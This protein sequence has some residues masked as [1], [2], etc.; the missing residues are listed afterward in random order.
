[1]EEIEE[2]PGPSLT[3]DGGIP[4]F[5]MP[6]GLVKHTT[7]PQLFDTEGGLLSYASDYREQLE[8]LYAS[9]EERKAAA[10][11]AIEEFG[12]LDNENAEEYSIWLL[13]A[14]TL[15]D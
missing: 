1:M 13:V 7:A 4:C 11:S 15:E 12:L 2:T 9:V 5:I 3:L 14:M 10:R 6:D 8:A